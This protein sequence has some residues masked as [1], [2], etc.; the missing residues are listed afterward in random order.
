MN[1]HCYRNCAQ[2]FVINSEVN[3]KKAIR[4][5][6]SAKAK[7]SKIR[8]RSLFYRAAP[9]VSPC[10]FIIFNSCIIFFSSPYHIE[11]FIISVFLMSLYIL[12]STEETFLNVC[13]ENATH[14]DK[15]M[16]S[17]LMTDSR[18]E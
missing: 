14:L 8:P 17:N 12:P 18:S 2:E 3:T 15:Y 11:T 6:F 10:I 4:K 5:I 16:F 13:Q 1:I 9:D 7:N